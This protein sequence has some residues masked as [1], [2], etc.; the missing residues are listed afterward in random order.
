LVLLRVPGQP[1]R[2]AQREFVGQRLFRNRLRA[3]EVD[4]ADLRHRALGHREVDADAVALER[5]HGRLH[6]GRVPA[7]RQVLA[8]QLLL[9][10]LE[11]G[12]VEYPPLRD[13]H[14]TQHLAQVVGLELLDAR[15][16]DWR[17]RRPLLDIH[18]QHFVLDVEAHV[19]EEP[20]R[21]KRAQRLLRLFLGHRLADL[22]RQ[23]AEHGARLGAL[24]PSTR[25]SLHHERLER[26][27]P[28]ARSGKQAQHGR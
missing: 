11:R 16:I 10:G 15:E 1:A 13:P 19:L 2:R 4:R 21:E 22:D 23:V 7:A 27:R 25:M 5:R 6:L 12:A 3:D 28:R 24:Q 18:D 9:G 26:L 8:L 17:D 20:G 14:F